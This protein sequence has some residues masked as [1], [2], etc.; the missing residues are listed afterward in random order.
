MR[1]E[2]SRRCHDGQGKQ[3]KLFAAIARKADSPAKCVF[4]GS[5]GTTSAYRSKVSPLLFACQS[6]AKKQLP[7]ILRRWGWWDVL[8]FPPQARVTVSAAGDV[9]VANPQPDE[10][11]F[12]I[13]LVKNV[14]SKVVGEI[15]VKS[16]RKRAVAEVEEDDA[17]AD[18]EA[19]F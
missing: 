16:T 18:D 19:A 8:P 6:C 11:N 7:C 5:R 4:V 12:W 13:A 3:R 14:E 10:L 2:A 9:A 1:G 17:E 15:W